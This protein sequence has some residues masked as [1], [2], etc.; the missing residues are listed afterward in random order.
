MK[1]LK[2]K[3]VQDV[4]TDSKY[5]TIEVDI[6]VNIDQISLI[7]ETLDGLNVFIV[8]RDKCLKIVDKDSIDQLYKECKIKRKTINE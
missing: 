5:V 4:Y 8:G 3:E 2:I 7:R 6:N 1:F